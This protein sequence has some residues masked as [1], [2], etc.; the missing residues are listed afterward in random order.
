M[1]NPYLGVLA[2]V[3]GVALLQLANGV[4]QLFL[5]L[6]LS[7]EQAAPS[8]IGVVVTRRELALGRALSNLIQNAVTY[9]GSARV[10]ARAKDGA[11]LIVIDDDG[12]GIPKAELERVFTP[13][14]RLERSRSRT[15]GGAG[16]GLAIARSVVRAHGGEVTLANGEG[17]GLRQTVRLPRSR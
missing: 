16:L 14:Y 5:P 1:P 3:A 6:R 12:P 15:T 8:A 9:G 17:G 2:I 4:F 13:F 7:L 10:Q 11:I